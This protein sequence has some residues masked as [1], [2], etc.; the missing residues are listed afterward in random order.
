LNRTGL[1]RLRSRW[2]R[3]GVE[4]T[5][6]Y[7]KIAFKLLGTVWRPPKT[8]STEIDAQLGQFS[9]VSDALGVIM[10]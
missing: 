4:V 1:G 10:I 5:L 6:V 8:V 2:K 3:I 9:L 7:L